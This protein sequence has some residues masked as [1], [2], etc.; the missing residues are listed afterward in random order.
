MLLQITT[1]HTPATDLGYLLMKHPDRMHQADL[2][3]GKAMVFFPEAS[4]QRCSAMLVLDIDPVEL[5]R[6][7]GQS[8]GILEQYVN[9]RP[10]VASSFLSVAI[11]EVFG[12]ALNGRSRERA[13]LAQQAIPLEAVIPSLP[14]RGG[15][16]LVRKLFEPLGYTVEIEQHALDPAIPEW[17]LSR[18][19]RLT[20]RG[21]QRLSDLL[22]HLYVLIPV[23]DDQKHY[24]FGED[25]IAKLLRHG[26]GWLA[27]HPERALITNRYLKRRRLVQAALAHL[28]SA[29]E[30]V[31]QHESSDDESAAPAQ[32]EQIRRTESLHQ[33]RLTVVAQT[34]HDLGVRR[35]VDLGCGEGRLLEKLLADRQFEQIVGMDVSY[36]I[37]ERAHERLRLERIPSHQAQRISLLHG[38]LLYQDVRLAGFDGAALVEVIEHLDLPRLEAFER[39]IFGYAK[40]G[41]VVITTPNREYNVRYAS[42]TPGNLRHRD[43]R[44]EWSRAEFRAW[45]ER[46]AAAYGYHAT[47]DMIGEVDPEVGAP[48][49]MAILRK[50]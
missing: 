42:L 10:Y 21:M 38:S 15:E 47:I 11:A 1:T 2:R 31:E 25:E 26:E 12:S 16:A 9:D 3:F 48:S 13:D 4:L 28:L 36:Q 5:V 34:L 22:A 45:A 35:V 7:R 30:V 6:G 32:L 43:H 40:P 20:I 18:I 33:Q 50:S 39:A 29:E 14:T 8:E 24:F 49:Q 41:V 27:G 44:F 37:L 23:L 19:V 17:G 46:V